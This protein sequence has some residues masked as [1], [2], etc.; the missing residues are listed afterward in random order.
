VSW[1]YPVKV[2]IA[3]AE[4]SVRP[5]DFNGEWRSNM[6]QVGKAAGLTPQETAICIVA[7]GLGINY[8]EFV[9]T[10]IGVWLNEHKVN[11][12]KPEI[13]NAYIRLGF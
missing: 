10:A 9:K 3:L 2:N 4:M 5:G 6:Q 8:P 13:V 12:N 11:V 7:Y 1:L